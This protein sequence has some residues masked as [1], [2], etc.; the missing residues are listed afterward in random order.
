MIPCEPRTVAAV[1][2]QD[3]GPI[4]A[5]VATPWCAR[6]VQ[7]QRQAAGGAVESRGTT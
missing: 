3:A 5:E 1:L 6:G 7:E 4:T 2:S